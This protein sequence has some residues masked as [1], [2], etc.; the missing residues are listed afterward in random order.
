MD[1]VA[2]DQ[3]QVLVIGVFRRV[4]AKDVNFWLMPQG[5]PR[6]DRELAKD[7]LLEIQQISDDTY[8]SLRELDV[9]TVLDNKRAT[10]VVVS[11]YLSLL[12]SKEEV[13]AQTLQSLRNHV[14][15]TGN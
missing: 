5:R 13:L 14:R 11:T 12:Q 1:G 2:A 10:A 3:G 7:V 4:R 6:S 15:G 8:A 9:S